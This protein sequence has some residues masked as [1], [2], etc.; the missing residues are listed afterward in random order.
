MSNKN[1][2]IILLSIFL[3]VGI[4]LNMFLLANNPGSACILQNEEKDGQSYESDQVVKNDI[5]VKDWNKTWG[6]S[7]YEYGYGIALDATGNI[8]MTGYTDSFGKGGK[9]LTLVKFYPN[10][11]KAWNKTWGGISDEEGNGIALDTVGNIYMTGYTDSFGGIDKDLAVVKFYSNG[12]KAWNKTWGGSYTEEG[13]GIVLDTAGNIYTTGR[14]SS[15]GEGTIN[16]ALV[17]FAP[18]GTKVWN[19]TWGG[20]NTEYG[21]GIALDTAGNIYTTGI[22]NS[23][24]EGN[25]AMAVVKFYPNGT[26]AWNVTWGGISMELGRGIALDTSGSIYT[27]GYTDSYSDFISN[28]ALVK[29]HPN[30]TRAW[31]VTWGGADFDEGYGIVLDAAGNIYTSGV[32]PSYGAGGQDLALVK[33]HPNGTKAWNVTWGGANSDKGYGLALD[34]AGNIYTTGNTYSYGAGNSDLTILKFYNDKAPN[35]NHPQD[36]VF[37]EDSAASIDWVLTDDLGT[38]YYRVF[39]NDVPAG[40]IPWTNNTNINYSI[41]TSTGGIFNYTLQ[42]NDSIGNWGNPDTVIITV[43]SEPQVN[44]PSDLNLFED[45]IGS[46]NWTI[47]D[48]IGPGYY[49]VFINGTPNNWLIW[50][51]NTN[52]NYSIDT[53]I[54]GIF[55]YTI[56]F[57]DSI[58]NMGCPDTVIIEIIPKET[59]TSI[60]SFLG[61]FVLLGLIIVSV[62]LKRKLKHYYYF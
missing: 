10:G 6:G 11:T 23:Y 8:Y 14:T 27:T 49:R 33:F 54:V 61:I 46:I 19:V 47:K 57:N 25:T 40:W 4:L 52:M 36:F 9:D 31:N 3:C 18:D 29:F 38:G 17:K 39:I 35:S 12:S 56:Q 16:L 60:P 37:A 55:N 22:T 59:T 45:S 34:A 20:A 51:N 58:G 44:H 7:S 32:T 43:D 5:I 15:Y 48:D 42:F 2:L 41:D 1:K 13:Y 28:L 62:F 50:T 26:R 53:S 30:G 21:Y 24:G